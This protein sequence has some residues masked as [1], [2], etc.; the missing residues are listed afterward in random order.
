[1]KNSAFN[2]VIGVLPRWLRQ[3]LLVMRITTLILL[4]ALLQV[5]ASSLAQKISIDKKNASIQTILNEISK[6]SGYDFFY[7]AN[8]LKKIKPISVSIKNTDLND[9]IKTSL[10]GLP[11]SYSI[12]NKTVVIKEAAPSLL[13]RARNVIQSIV[14]DLTVKGRVVDQD[15]KPLPNASIRVK[16][17]N[18]VTNTN[19]NGEFELKGVDEDAVLLVSYVGYKQLE[20]PL[21]DAAMPL[22]IKLNVATGELEEV[23]VTYSTGYQNIPKERSTGSF[24]QVD[25]ETY[26]RRVSGD[27]LDR[28]Y[29]VTS[30]LSFNPNPA[31]TGQS[32]I[33]VR[34]ISTINANKKPLIVIDNVP[35]EGDINNINPNDIESV[36]VLK[37]AA[38]ASIWGVRAGNGVIVLRSK[39]GKYNQDT[40]INFNSNITLGEKQ[41]IFSV[42]T[43]SS[44]EVVDFQKKL[45]NTGYWNEY[46]DTYPS[47]GIFTAIPEAAEILLAKRRGAIDDITAQDK[48]VQLENVDV[49]NDISKYLLQNSVNQ[50]Y[51][52]NINGGGEKLNYYVSAGHDYNRSTSV[53]SSNHRTTLRIDNSYKPFSK[54]EIKGFIS[55]VQAK[56][57]TN[58]VSGSWATYTRLADEAG[59]PLAVV[60]RL[61]SAYTDT[62][63]Y[64]ALLNWQYKPLDELLNKEITASTKDIRVGGTVNYSINS[65]INATVD[66]QFQNSQV[67]GKNYQNE[68]SYYTRDLINRYMFKQGTATI[69]PVPLGGILDLGTSEYKSWNLRG[70]LNV[71]RGWGKN[72]I[73]AIAGYELRESE[74]D[75]YSIRKYG[76]DPETNASQFVNYATSYQLR[77]SGGANTVP[78]ESPIKGGISRYRSFYGNGSY[79]YNSRYTISLSGRIDGSNFYGVKANQ[80][81]VPLWSAGLSW[82]LSEEKF[83]RNTVIPFL[84]IRATYGYN[85][86]TNNSATA[87]SLISYYNNPAIKNLGAILVSPPNP[88]L[89]W[90][91][92][93]IINMG[94]DVASKDK[95]LSVSIDYYTKKGIDLISEITTFPSSGVASYTG[96][97]ATLASKGWDVVLN[98]INVRNKGFEWNTQFLFSYNAEKVTSYLVLPSNVSDYLGSSMSKPVIG[99]PLYKMYGYQWGGLDPVMGSSRAYIN[100]GIVGASDAYSNAKIEDLVYIG[101]TTPSKFG[102]FRNTISKWG[103]S[104]SAN[105]NYKFGYYFSRPSFDYAQLVGNSTGHSDYA[106]RWQ[107]PGDELLTDVPALPTNVNDPSYYVYQRSN[108]LAEK[109]DHIRL[110]D[111]RINYTV[112]S[113]NLKH[114][115]IRNCQFYIYANNLGVIWSANTGDLDPDYPGLQP[116]K[117]IALGLNIGL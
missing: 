54:L 103:I 66:Y 52:F 25:N 95:R 9:A 43:M 42:S 11:L 64:P 46:D 100:N 76:Y 35:Y 75:N 111:M 97:N 104:I 106:K 59:N 41:R 15:G 89:R 31:N 24:A 16:G 101:R 17:K 110:Q 5:S 71:N 87:Y 80:R 32:S 34:G 57:N 70:Q 74:T 90:E 27:I 53:G 49:R 30:S 13:E 60:N 91:K 65:F 83:F 56:S 45:F 102:S 33:T 85:G 88:Q 78:A 10:Q 107:S 58:N 22:E 68:N 36:T 4:A 21:K 26:N 84:K 2:H 113:K 6:Q 93:R 28:L 3:T 108:V 96:N 23:K 50:Q 40:K 29:D 37:D 19:Q 69:Y 18:A 105:I 98:T 55:Y 1:M 81:I 99:R 20:I 51:A 62:A 86:N 116:S 38:A 8:A 92:S 115:P 77:P 67:L 61:R 72:Q 14:K 7:D 47:Q 48:L 73:S 12:D 82:D 112:N 114:L 63:S 117:S 39:T 79:T 109:G 94:I 44:K